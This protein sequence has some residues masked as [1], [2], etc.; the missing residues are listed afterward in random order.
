M[1]RIGAAFA[2]RVLLVA[3]FSTAATALAQEPVRPLE[4][5]DRSSPRA[6]LQ[7]FLQS[8]DALAAF[9][10]REYIPTPTRQ[11]F[12]HVA[13]MAEIPLR[14][15]DLSDVPPSARPKTGRAAAVAL[16]E[17]LNRIGVPRW[18]DIPGPAADDAS[19]PPRWVIPHTEIALFRIGEG[20]REGEYVFSA[21]TVARADEFYER[22]RTLP[23]VRAVPLPGLPELLSEGGGWPIRFDWIQELPQWLRSTYA[24]QSVWK[25]IALTLV[26][27]FALLL[28]RVVSRLSRRIRDDRP[29]LRAVVR[30]AVP[31]FI[32]LATPVLAY[33]ALVPINM[34][35]SV[36]SAIELVA[37]AV[38]FGAAAWLA[39]RA[40][41]VIAEAIIASPGIASESIDAY[42]IRIG[43][44]LLGLASVA[45]LLALGAERLGV[46]VY[47]IM[48]GLGVGGLAI[49]LAAQPTIEN[50]IGSL[51][52]FADKPVRVGDFCR[53]GDEVGTVEAIGMRSTRIRGLDRALTTIPNRTLA[54]M[55]IVNLTRRDRM[56]MNAVIGVRLETTPEQLRDLLA[57]LTEMLAGHA[58]I[59]ADPAVRFVGFASAS[60]NVEI[61]AYATTT[62]YPEFRAIQ[63][64]VYLRVMDIVEQS[65]T[66]LAMPAQRVYFARDHDE[67]R[68]AE[69]EANPWRD[70]GRQIT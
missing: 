64:D 47:G 68:A 4:P 7:T 16:Y 53:Y 35:G 28:L 6:A 63:E 20:S 65:G 32:L 58:R 18:E 37:T 17:T 54:N 36:A 13:R 50:L 9:L 25:W 70:E 44:R 57:K 21:E 34:I 40:A 11:E 46:P 14:S 1:Q 69:G 2:C 27:G 22:V 60:L 29:L 24:G 39:W 55:P 48:A 30:I 43:L 31:V 12:T 38:T 61:T 26:T 52:L 19:A 66:A 59:A 42:V 8:T 41:P 10:Q 49:A 67:A 51:S 15:L 5:P 62:M 45:V 3:W 33:I 56:L 23:Y